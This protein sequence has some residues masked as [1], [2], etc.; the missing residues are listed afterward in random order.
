MIMKVELSYRQ[1][2]LIENALD[3]YTYALLHGIIDSQTD[4]LRQYI[5]ERRLEF[6]IEERE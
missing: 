5:F 4:E 2:R 6:P 1:I 3:F